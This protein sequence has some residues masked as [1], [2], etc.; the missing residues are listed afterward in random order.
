MPRSGCS[1][2][3]TIERPSTGTPSRPR[4]RDSRHLGADRRHADRG[5]AFGATILPGQPPGERMKRAI[6]ILPLL[7]F[8]AATAHAQ[9]EDALRQY[10]EG[11]RVVLRQD[12]PATQLGV[13]TVSY[14][15]LRAHET[16]HD[17][18]CRLLLEK[19]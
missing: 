16:R 6:R 19:K 14:T 9:S 13:D 10:F 2:I 4:D 5:R 3:E 7:L 11:K 12:M 15:H 1:A 8:T 18:V 17:L